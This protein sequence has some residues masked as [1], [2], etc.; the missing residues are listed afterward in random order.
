ML[1]FCGVRPL[2]S[3]EVA[4]ARTSLRPSG[5]EPTATLASLWL[6][7]SWDYLPM[8]SKSFSSEERAL[9]RRFSKRRA[10]GTA[11]SGPTKQT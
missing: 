6:T 5:V 2:G 3:D 9:R 4:V 1:L 7:A 11:F 8:R 10:N